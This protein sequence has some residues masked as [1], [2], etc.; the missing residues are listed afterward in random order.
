MISI[1]KKINLAMSDRLC[2]CYHRDEENR[3]SGQKY[4]PES[5]ALSSLFV[6]CWMQTHRQKV[7]SG[8]NFF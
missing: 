7:F 2:V 3:F 5:Q 6:K 1:E 8:P 4:V